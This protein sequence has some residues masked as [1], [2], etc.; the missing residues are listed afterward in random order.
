MFGRG[1]FSDVPFSSLNQ[2]TRASLFGYSALSSTFQYTIYAATQTFATKPT[3]AVSNQPFRGVL[4]NY[5]FKRTVLSGS[6]GGVAT[7]DGQMTIDNGDSFYDFLPLQYSLSGREIALKAGRESDSYDD[8]FPIAKLTA[9]SW[10]I[11]ENFVTINLRD[12]VFKLDVAIQTNLYSGAGGINGGSDLAGKRIPLAYG[13]VLNAA[14]PLVVPSLLIYQVHES[15]VQDITAVY[16]R[17]VSLTKGTN[18]A[19]YALLAAASPAAGSYATCLALG[20]FK[21]GSTPTGTITADIQGD[22]TSSF[23][24]TSADICK[25]ILSTRSVL[26][27]PT[28][29]FT[30]SFDLVNT[31]QP[32]AIGYYIGEDE[33]VTIADV[34]TNIMF[35]IGGWFG[36]DRNGLVYLKILTAP[37]GTPK[38][39]FTKEDV[40]GDLRREPLPDNLS[41]AVW[42]W[43]VAYQRVWETQ[44]DLA[45][46][47]SST[48]RAFVANA[49][50]LAEASNTAIKTDFPF[51][52]DPEPVQAYFANQADAQTEATRLL[53]LY[54]TTR[55]LYR[56]PLPRRIL[57][58]G[59]G[60]VISI[61]YPRWD[62]SAGRLMT[63][64]ETN[65]NI[66]SENDSVEVVCYG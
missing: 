15:S 49:V 51:S 48:R 1:P 25:R 47:V 63:I 60:D 52:K 65:E 66:H 17:G 16:D 45:G 58:T 61:T 64:L 13:T 42:R 28:N 21:L 3:D 34:C 59:L 27:Y 37:S 2:Q 43:R 62:L 8:Y 4:Q 29:F 26:T 54:K 36:F 24:S 12:Y 22:N 35:G 57:M 50:R 41:P 11:D 23:V 9:S 38:D 7:G 32:A 44:D 46:S 31:Q 40:F 30:S 18:Y 33:T 20:L 19:T 14:P 10:N 6:I 39:S 53:N 5:S 55:Q 56:I